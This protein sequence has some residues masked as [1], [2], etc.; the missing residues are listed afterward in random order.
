VPKARWL[1]KR[2]SI[3]ILNSLTP[4]PSG[5]PLENGES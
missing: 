5:L 2:Y 3:E 1:S 4:S